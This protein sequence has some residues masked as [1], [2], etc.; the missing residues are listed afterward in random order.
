MQPVSK[1]GLSSNAW[2]YDG[3]WKKLSEEQKATHSAVLNN[4][5]GTDQKLVPIHAHSTEDAIIKAKLEAIKLDGIY[6]VKKI[7]EHR[8]ENNPGGTAR[9][10]FNSDLIQEVEDDI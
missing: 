3:E 7:I 5:A 4:V 10:V 8:S 9:I 6:E 2:A 1:R